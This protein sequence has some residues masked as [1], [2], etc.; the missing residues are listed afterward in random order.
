MKKRSILIVSL[1]VLLGIAL[2][3]QSTTPQIVAQEDDD[4]DRMQR[5]INVSGTGQVTAKPDVA[6]ITVGVETQAEEAGAVLSQNSE[7]MQAIIDALKEAGIPQENIQTRVVQLN[8][9]YETGPREGDQSGPPEIVGY[10]AINLVEV[11]VTDPDSVGEVLDSAAQAGA[12]RISDIR[13]EISDPSNLMDQARELAWANALHKAEQLASLADEE[14]GD[15]LRVHESS[16]AP[17]PLPGRGVVA[18]E[19]AS[20]PVE[21]G[22]QT[23]TVNLDVTWLLR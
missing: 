10:S 13:F 5:T 17:S 16:Q 3:F 14:L 23:I 2:L 11:R 1:V 4:D 22:T 6:V 15:V 19:A 21:A 12:N 8:P 20:V 9:R 7:Q 18:A